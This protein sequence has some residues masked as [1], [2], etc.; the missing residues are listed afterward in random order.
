M[1]EPTAGPVVGPAFYARRGGRAADWWTLLH[2]PYT[3]WH[4]SYV[5]LGAAMAP[6]LDWF[7]LAC[8]LVAFF[9]AVGLTA[10]AL[11]ELHGRPL[12]TGIGDRTLWGVAVAALVG[13]GAIGVYGV[14]F[15]T[16]ETNWL[17]AVCVPVGALLVVGYNLELFGGRLHTD[18]GFAWAWGGFP[19]A[20]GYL[21]QSPLQPPGPTVASTVAAAAAVLAAVGTAAA[22]RVLST[23]ARGLRR[24]TAGVSGTIRHDDGR[25]EPIDRQTLL[26]APERALRAMS[27][28]LPLLAAAALLARA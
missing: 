4:L 13:A 9:L 15:H 16:T 24:R 20:V 5:G 26:A 2:P 14:W 7:A 6:A 1:V 22:Q 25:V 10:H 18:A 3:A 17:L 28:A 11:D 8:S 21:A 12:G 23:S 19:V 27:W